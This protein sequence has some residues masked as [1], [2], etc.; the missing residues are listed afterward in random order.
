M[1]RAPAPVG[2]MKNTGCRWFS[3]S[4]AL[5]DGRPTARTAPPGIAPWKAERVVSW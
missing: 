3:S 1:L 2:G 5:N 4:G